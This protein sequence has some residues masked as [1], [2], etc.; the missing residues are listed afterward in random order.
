M[1][2]NHGLHRCR[3]RGILIDSVRRRRIFDI[4]QEISHFRLVLRSELRRVAFISISDL[5]LFLTGILVLSRM[6]NPVP[7]RSSVP[8]WPTPENCA[9]EKGCVF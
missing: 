6:V 5:R 7:E 4:G 8:Y 2:R 1:R 3:F 9:K